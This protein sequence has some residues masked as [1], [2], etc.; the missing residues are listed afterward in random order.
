MRKKLNPMQ[1]LFVS[2]VMFSLTCFFFTKYSKMLMS[3]NHI[4]FNATCWIQKHTCIYFILFHIIEDLPHT[5][6]AHLFLFSCWHMAL[7]YDKIKDYHT[8][9]FLKIYF[10]SFSV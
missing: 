1:D 10:F 9:T 2:N 6:I 8:C 4:H 3:N 5:F 7:Y